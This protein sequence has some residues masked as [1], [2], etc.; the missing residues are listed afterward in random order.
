MTTA[1]TTI[2]RGDGSLILDPHREVVRS[3]AD[4]RALWT[5]HA[6]PAAALPHVDFATRVV[7][8][9]FAGERP[10]PGYGVE[11]VEH[12]P[13]ALHVR[14]L[15]PPPGAIAAQVIVTPFHIVS[16]PARGGAV[17]FVDGAAPEPRAPGSPAAAESSTGLEPNM[18]A[19]LAY[20]A[21]PFSGLLVLLVERTSPFVR[22]HAYQALLG[23]GGLGLLAV[24]LLLGA[25]AALL[26]SPSAFTV[27]YWL[28]FACGL[29]WLVVWAVALVLAF[30][31][32]SW[33][34]PLVGAMA[35]RRSASGR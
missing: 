28:A 10:T 29:L 1:L 30:R 16:L 26:V 18:A 31:G 2:A 14:E 20:L 25:F 32:R 3:E 35:A 23:L 5:R 21:G 17:T 19:A 9:V 24:G 4:W 8:A 15:A 12:A 6:G 7:A 11:I 27:L 33:H 34:M 13:G 22:L